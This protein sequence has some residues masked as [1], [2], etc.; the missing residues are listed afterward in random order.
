MADVEME[1]S[2]PVETT[3]EGTS[4]VVEPVETE[5]ST[6]EPE[7]VETTAETETEAQADTPA[8]EPKLYAGKYKSIEDFEKGYKEINGAF[9]KAK[10]FESKYNELV[11]QQQEYADKMR[12]MQL[13][14]ANQRG[15][16]TAEDAQ[17]AD[18][19]AL[20]EFQYYWQNQNTIAPDYAQDVQNLLTNYYQSGNRAY[21]EEAKRYFS[22]NFIERVA[23]ATKGLETNLRGE[24]SQRK[25]A[26]R[27]K[28]QTELA[29][30]L[31]TDFAEF[32]GDIKENEGKAQALQMFCNADFINS[33]EDMK[34]FEQ[35]YSNIEKSA[36]AKYLK[37]QEAKKAIEEVKEKAV[38]SNSNDVVEMKTNSITREELLSNPEMYKKAIAKYGEAKIDEIIMKG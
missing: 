27:E 15:F 17:V 32:L 30:T 31:K 3:A 33:V 10:E 14:Q 2:T 22:S 11:K 16:E 5:T 29:N 9:T 38:I 21:L 23:V 8:E 26:E 19:V 1:V 37:E 7:T 28:A 24:I 18:K 13:Q 6:Q 35:I 4:G 20:A 25:S 12:A 34:V 36:V